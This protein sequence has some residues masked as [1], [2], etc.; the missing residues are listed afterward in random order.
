MKG[1]DIL[2]AFWRDSARSARFLMFSAYIAVP[3]IGFLFHIR[4]WTFIVLVITI[5]LM[6]VMEYFGYTPPVAM[7]ALRARV[8]G[9]KITRRRQFFDKKLN[10]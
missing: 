2:D 6:S 5:V 9:K 10:K 4:L 3:L 1:V 7:L 8:A